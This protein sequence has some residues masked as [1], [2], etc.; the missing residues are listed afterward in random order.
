MSKEL[1]VYTDAAVPQDADLIGGDDVITFS[2]LR[3]ILNVSCTKTVTNHESIIICYSNPPFPVWVWC[4]DHTDPELIAQLSDALKEHFPAE[5]GYAWNIS[6]ALFDVLKAHDPYFSDIKTDMGLLSYRLEAL[7]APTRPCSGHFD[8]IYEDDFELLCKL[9]HDACLEMEGIDNS[10]EFCR[11]RIKRAFEEGSLFT[12]RNDEGEI[13]AMASRSDAP[14]LSKVICVYTLPGHRR[15]GYAMH[16]VHD[17]CAG[18]IEDGLTAILY[19]DAGYEA[20]NA[21][22]R[23]IGFK[24]IGSLI[25][26]AK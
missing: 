1:L 22:Y 24:E 13:L 20:S 15:N 10:E 4:K 8:K 25:K 9:W 16:L 6:E 3:S 21:C 26:V 23:K 18:I 11:E 14:P 19:T 12:W 5:S 2:V 7:T 17:V